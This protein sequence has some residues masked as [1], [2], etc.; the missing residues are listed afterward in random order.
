ME[1]FLVVENNKIIAERFAKCIVEG[2][3][4]TNIT[5]ENAQVGDILLGG[6]WKK[7]PQEIAE[8]AKQARISVLKM[9]IGNKKLLDM[10]CTAEQT[11]LK[12][13]LGL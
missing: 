4:Y 8:Q 12:A 13:L 11:E 5:H 3:I 9:E 2:E 7:D 6:V 1:R 10:D